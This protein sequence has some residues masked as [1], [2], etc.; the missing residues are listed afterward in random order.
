MSATPITSTSLCPAP[1][2]SR[3][4]TSFRAAS[5]TS[6][7]CSVDSAIPPGSRAPHRPDEDA[8]VEEVV[9]QPDPVAEQRAVRERARRVDRDHADGLFLPRTCLTSALISDDFRPRRAGDADRVARPV[10]RIEVADDGRTRAASPFST[11]VIARASARVSPARTPRRASRAST[12]AA[13]PRSRRLLV[14]RAELGGVERRSRHDRERLHLDVLLVRGDPLARA[15]TTRP[16]QR[17]P[18]SSRR[19]PRPNARRTHPD[20]PA[21]E[22]MPMKSAL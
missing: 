21:G 4:I 8:R 2:V 10:S 20:E 18:P 3:K 15:H 9:A 11:S 19:R 14:Q 13:A 16:R 12:P 17:H 1:T 5:S 7:A 22:S 6:I